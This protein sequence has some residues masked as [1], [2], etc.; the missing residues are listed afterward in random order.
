VPRVIRETGLGV[1]SMH[2]TT[3]SN[4]MVNTCPR[5]SPGGFDACI[6]ANGPTVAAPDSP[7]AV[8]PDRLVVQR[9]GR[10][11]FKSDPGMPAGAPMV[12]CE[13]L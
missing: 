4:H 5:I 11:L 1:S 6:T 13:M 9:T 2:D 3:F 7:L 8:V 10:A 12:A